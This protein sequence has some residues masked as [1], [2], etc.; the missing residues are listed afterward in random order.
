MTPERMQMLTRDLATKSAK[1]RKLAGEGAARADIA[2]FLG[3]RYQHVRNVLVHEEGRGGTEVAAI[4]QGPEK[5]SAKIR[6]GPNGSVS[7]P[8]ALREALAIG[9]GDVLFASAANDGE[10]HLLTLP[11]AIRQAQAIVRKFV[12]EGASLVDELLEDRRREVEKARK[13]G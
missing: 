5:A 6:V 12:P 10:L 13:D 2:R 9:E 3:I 7:L 1:I 8:P 11:A 4:R